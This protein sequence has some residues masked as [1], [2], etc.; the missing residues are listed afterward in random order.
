MDTDR[1]QVGKTRW[2][3]Y[4]IGYHLVWI[5]KYRRKIFVGGVEA[6]TK[7]RNSHSTKCP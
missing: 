5:L 3:H 2:C 4:M 1:L 7:I 6:E